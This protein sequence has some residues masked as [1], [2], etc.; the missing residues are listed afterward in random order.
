MTAT[1]STSAPWQERAAN[2][3]AKALAAIPSAW[4]IPQDLVQIDSSKWES[5]KV[6]MMEMDVFRRSGVLSE[7]EISITE[8]YDVASLLRAL[9]SGQITA[10]EATVAFSKRAAIAQ[11]L[12]SYVMLYSQTQVFSAKEMWLTSPDELFDGDL[13]PGSRG[14]CCHA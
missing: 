4:R 5:T 3:R 12:V 10:V 14:A 11:Q 13:F 8:S 2:K 1:T 7:K 9:A 6:N